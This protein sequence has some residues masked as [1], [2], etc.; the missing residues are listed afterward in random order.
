MVTSPV[1]RR[2]PQTKVFVA[3]L[4]VPLN[5]F[6]PVHVVPPDHV[7]P[8]LDSCEYVLEHRVGKSVGIALAMYA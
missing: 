4:A 6:E 2:S 7:E 3:K 5:V 1:S 8:C